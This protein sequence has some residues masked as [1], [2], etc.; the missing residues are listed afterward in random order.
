MN[1]PNCD[2]E[3]KNSFLKSNE[4]LSDMAVN[5]INDKLNL[6]AKS[7]C[8]SC[9]DDLYKKAKVTFEKS[10][11]AECKHCHKSVNIS[12]IKDGYCNEC[13]DP[14]FREESVRLKEEKALEIEKMNSIF[15]TTEVAINIDIDKR[16]DLI[17]SECIYGIN[18][19]KDFFSG[20]RDIVGGN[21]KSLEKSLKDAK[22]EVMEDLKNQAYSLGGD[23]VIGVRIEHTYNNAG[24]GSIM[25]VFATGTVVKFKV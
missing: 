7:Y 25:S 15:I 4:Q 17:S 19:V 8:N 11:K 9:G 22:N 24:G 1:C 21:V 10:Q 3:I 6:N 12:D 23:A 5:F 2:A 18:I 14:L 13:S 20:I 16:L